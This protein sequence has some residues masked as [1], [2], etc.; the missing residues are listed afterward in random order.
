MS[1]NKGHNSRVCIYEGHR[2]RG[3]DH[4]RLLRDLCSVGLDPVG[5]GAR[6][7]AK[8][9]LLS[10]PGQKRRSKATA[11]GHDCFIV[12]SLVDGRMCVGVALQEIFRAVASCCVGRWWPPLTSCEVNCGFAYYWR[13]LRW[14][15][16]DGVYSG[17]AWL[18]VTRWR[19]LR[20][21]RTKCAYRERASQMKCATN[22]GGECLASEPGALWVGCCGYDPEN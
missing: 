8:Q 17:G 1:G 22:I 10:R 9:A 7:S 2:G 5:H 4:C 11:R 6:V 15:A 3:H 18:I 13:V 19:A 21:P 14:H 16:C 20:L 12:H